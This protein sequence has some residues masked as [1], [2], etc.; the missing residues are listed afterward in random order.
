MHIDTAIIMSMC[1][2]SSLGATLGGRVRRR[3]SGPATMRVCDVSP[4]HAAPTETN[5]HAE[6]GERAIVLFDTV[7][8]LSTGDRQRRAHLADITVGEH[9]AGFGEQLGVSGVGV[10]SMTR[11]S[12]IDGTR[13]PAHG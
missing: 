9:H 5:T 7:P 8:R 3:T 1:S 6:Q 10:L 4:V 12:A 2:E 11:T 13:R